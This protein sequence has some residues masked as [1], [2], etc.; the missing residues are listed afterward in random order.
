[1]V[2]AGT[3]TAGP[4]EEAQSQ[5]DTTRETL[6]LYG[7]TDAEIDK[8]DDAERVHEYHDGIR[9]GVPNGPDPV[10]GPKKN[11]HLN[12]RKSAMT[13]KAIELD[14]RRG[15]AAQKA[16]DLRRCWQRWSPMNE[17]CVNGRVN[18]KPI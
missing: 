15:M 18:W 11:D 9:A 14:G 7:Y 1:V 2:R 10:A 8:M 3:W 16:T 5:A 4:E 12:T 13:D 6:K 17:R